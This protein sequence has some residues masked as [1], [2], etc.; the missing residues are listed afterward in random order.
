MNQ[1]NFIGYVDQDVELK[2]TQSGISVCEF[3]IGIPRKKRSSDQQ[4]VWDYITIVA[5]RERAEFCSRYL[6]K[7]TKLR[8][9]TTLKTDS[10]EDKNGVKR[11]KFIFELDEAEFCERKQQQSPATAAQNAQESANGA[12]QGKYPQNA[13]TSQNGAVSGTGAYETIADDEELPF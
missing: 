5:W 6:V 8:V 3:D 10:Y 2:T 12:G 11:K 9:T 4:A 7:G 13:E 1:C